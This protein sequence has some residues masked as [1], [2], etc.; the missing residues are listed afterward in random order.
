M[1]IYE[2]IS[3]KDPNNGQL[4]L[5]LA[6][7]YRDNG[8]LTKS[9]QQL[10]KAFISDKVNIETK[11]TILASY[12]SIVNANDTIKNQAFELVKVLDSIYTNNAET[13]ALYGDLYYATA[14][15][16]LAKKS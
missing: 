2:H 4:S 1:K 14:N 11:L 7:F 13:Y 5:T 3:V 12:L 6:N 15:K 16:E 8:D 9:Y 10:K